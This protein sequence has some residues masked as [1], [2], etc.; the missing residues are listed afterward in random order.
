MLEP[1]NGTLRITRTRLPKM[2]ERA[3]YPEPLTGHPG[4]AVAADPNLIPA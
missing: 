3:G 2:L 1:W 4:I